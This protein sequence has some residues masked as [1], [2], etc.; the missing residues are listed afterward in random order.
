MWPDIHDSVCI[1]MP[2]CISVYMKGSITK[3]TGM[4]QRSYLCMWQREV[5]G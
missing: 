4:Y 5:S 2:A 3:K 1:S